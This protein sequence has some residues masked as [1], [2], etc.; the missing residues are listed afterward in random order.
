MEALCIDVKPGTLLQLPRDI[1]CYGYGVDPLR[2]GERFVIVTETE[3]EP[4]GCLVKAKSAQGEHIRFAINTD[5]LEV[6][7]N[8][9]DDLGIVDE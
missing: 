8:T 9:I 6:Y 4:H 2:S 1:E 5:E 7:A 3:E